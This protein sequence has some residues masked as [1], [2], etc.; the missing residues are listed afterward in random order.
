M[1]VLFCFLVLC[2]SLWKGNSHQL[3]VCVCVCLVGSHQPNLGIL[4]TLSH[5]KLIRLQSSEQVG[6]NIME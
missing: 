2:C 4:L 3:C 1:C 5:C 6:Y